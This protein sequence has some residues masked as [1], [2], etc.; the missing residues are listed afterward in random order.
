MIRMKPFH[1]SVPNQ[2][3]E[4]INTHCSTLHWDDLRLL[5]QD[6]E[7]SGRNMLSTA[8]PGIMLRMMDVAME[9]RKDRV[10]RAQEARLAQALQ[11]QAGGSLSAD[12]LK[13]LVAAAKLR[14][15]DEECANGN[16]QHHDH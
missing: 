2:L 12:Q 8:S 3:L 6:M 16:C 13:T 5:L 1:G 15:K 10:A 7:A 11:A 14:E 9:R 4:S